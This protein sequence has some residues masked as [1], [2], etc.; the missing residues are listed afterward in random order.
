MRP[1]HMVA[2]YLYRRVL[3]GASVDTNGQ[4]PSDGFMVRYGAFPTVAL[5][6]GQHSRLREAITAFVTEHWQAVR[7]RGDAYFGIWMDQKA[8][9]I[10][11]DVSAELTD[12]DD[13]L[14]R[15]RRLGE[16]AIY[17]VAL[18]REIWVQT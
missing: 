15:A 11:L 2:D 8:D 1:E 18:R 4:A 12:R 6:S 13:A 16:R 14:N 7:Q 9:V 5:R 17:D 10:Y 3:T